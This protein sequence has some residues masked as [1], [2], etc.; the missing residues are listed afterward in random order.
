MSTEETSPRFTAPVAVAYLKERVYVAFT[1]LAIVLVLYNAPGHQDG[2]HAFAVLLSGLLGVA[3]AAFA[4]DVIAHLAVHRHFPHGSELRHLLRSTLGA[5]STA[6]VPLILIA[7]AWAD[8]LDLSTAL[9][10]SA[11]LYIAILGTVGWLAVRRSHLSGGQKLAAFAM[12]V[13]LALVVLLI[14]IFAHGH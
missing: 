10:L 1:G 8:V 3:V 6:V 5:L 14:Q 9:I 12:L 7:L 11:Y 13:A 2:A 4:S